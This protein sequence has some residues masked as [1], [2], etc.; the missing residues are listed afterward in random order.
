[1]LRLHVMTSEDWPMWRQVR[2][3]AL[4]DSPHAFKARLDDWSR[5]GEKQWRERLTAPGTYNLVAVLDDRAVG[6][7]R[8]VPRGGAVQ[9]RSV[10]VGPEARGRGVGDRLIAAVEAWALRTEADALE[11]AVLPDND[12][13][14]AL[15]RRNGFGVAGVDAAGQQRM[16]KHLRQD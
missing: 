11:L 6:V 7:A 5:G 3:A 10:W 1:M 8:G 2:L 13:A 15:Y 4:A 16:T 12:S 9:L 14:L